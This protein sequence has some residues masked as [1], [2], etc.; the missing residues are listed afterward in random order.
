MSTDS[1]QWHDRITAVIRR[2]LLLQNHTVADEQRSVDMWKT[3]D[4]AAC[5]KS[6]NSG[7]DWAQQRR[8]PADDVARC[9]RGARSIAA[10]ARSQIARPCDSCGVRASEPML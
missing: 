4:K 5:D 1:R 2:A 10:V 6:V 7:T 3:L 9:V 8:E